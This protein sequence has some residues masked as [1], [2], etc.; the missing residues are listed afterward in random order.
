MLAMEELER[1]S[2]GGGE[3]KEK[4]NP[5]PQRFQTGAA[6]SYGDCGRGLFGRRPPSCSGDS[7]GSGQLARRRSSISAQITAFLPAEEMYG[8]A[9]SGASGACLR[10][11]FGNT[12]QKKK[13][14]GDQTQW[15][16]G[17]CSRGLVLF[18]LFSFFITGVWAKEIRL[19][20]C[21]AWVK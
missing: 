9:G 3:R 21:T 13:K 12:N 7:A 15:L 11:L 2:E 4:K 17:G 18:S 8:A 14:A 16:Q 6:G 1:W 19:G 20:K 10:V 5:P